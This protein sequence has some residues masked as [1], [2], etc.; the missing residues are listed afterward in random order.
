MDFSFNISNGY[1]EGLIRGFKIGI[2][3]QQDYLNLVQCETLDGK[4][5]SCSHI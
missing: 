2:L 4:S 1:L 5:K 3:K